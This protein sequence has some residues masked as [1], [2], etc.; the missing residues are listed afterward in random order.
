M[1]IDS[2]ENSR[3]LVSVQLKSL[4]ITERISHF[5]IATER[6]QLFAF[7]TYVFTLEHLRCKLEETSLSFDMKRRRRRNNNKEL[8]QV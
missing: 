5:D 8:Y 6:L 7:S 3:A 2:F 4:F 1:C